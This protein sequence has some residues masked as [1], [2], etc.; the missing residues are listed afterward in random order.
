MIRLDSYFF[1]K[2]RN[3]QLGYQ[4]SGVCC[5]YFLFLF[6]SPWWKKRRFLGDFWGDF[7]RLLVF[8]SCSF[9]IFVEFKLP[10]LNPA[11]EPG[12]AITCRR[13]QQKEWNSPIWTGKNSCEWPITLVLC[14]FFL[15]GWYDPI[16]YRK[17]HKI[18]SKDQVMNIS[19][20]FGFFVRL[21]VQGRSC[22]EQLPGFFFMECHKSQRFWTERCNDVLFNA[23]AVNLRRVP[24]ILSTHRRSVVKN[25]DFSVVLF[26]SDS[27]I[28]CAGK[29]GLVRLVLTVFF[30]VSQT[31]MKL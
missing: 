26:W 29:E 11:A 25:S 18:N 21:I 13:G 30:E 8:L 20:A 12:L 14:R 10:E 28:C 15:R 2:G 9:P 5:C 31:F 22:C 7:P 6:A 3:H 17:S 4:V 1:K 16:W 24:W 19:F 27:L 23:V